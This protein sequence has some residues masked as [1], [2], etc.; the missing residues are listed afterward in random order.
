MYKLHHSL[1]D[2]LPVTLSNKI[3]WVSGSDSYRIAVTAKKKLSL[4]ITW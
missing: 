4:F 2:I 1:S 3:T